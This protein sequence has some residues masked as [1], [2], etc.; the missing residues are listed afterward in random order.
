MAYS[1]HGNCCSS[2]NFTKFILWKLFEKFI[3]SDVFCQ[4]ALTVFKADV[5]V[6]TV[7]FRNSDISNIIWV[8]PRLPKTAV[9]L[10]IN[11]SSIFI[12]GQPS[13]SFIHCLFQT[14]QLIG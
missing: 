2:V 6:A 10:Y 1:I 9:E 7:I 3:E 5:L 14:L 11:R 8:Y 12:M 13:P 4:K